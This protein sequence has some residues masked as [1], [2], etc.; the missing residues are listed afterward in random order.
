M[1]VIIIL[2]GYFFLLITLAGCDEYLY[3]SRAGWELAGLAADISLAVKVN[4]QLF[5]G[6]LPVSYIG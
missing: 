2:Q 3:R 1:Q 5:F 6:P 4:W